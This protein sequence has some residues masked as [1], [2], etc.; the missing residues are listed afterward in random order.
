MTDNSSSVKRNQSF[1]F[2]SVATV[3]NSSSPNPSPKKELYVPTFKRLVTDPKFS[4]EHV[5]DNQYKILHS[6]KSLNIKP[7]N[8]SIYLTGIGSVT[9]IKTDVFKNIELGSLDYSIL[10]KSL[11]KKTSIIKNKSKVDPLPYITNGYH[12]KKNLISPLFTCCDQQLNPKILNKVLYQQKEKES[13]ARINKTAGNESKLYSKSYHPKKIVVPDGPKDYLNKTKELNRIRYCMNL[14]TESIKEH[15]SNIKE[16][17][18]SLDFTIKSINTYKNNLENKFL[19]EYNKQIRALDKILLDEKIEDEKLKSQLVK[20]QKENTNLLYKIKKNE[21]NTQY[22]EKWLILQI[23]IKERIHI[24]KKKIKNYINENYN[25]KLIIESP[26]EFDEIFKEK[27]KKNRQLMESLNDINREKHE[28]FLN[29]EEIKENLIDKEMAIEI[30]EKEKLLSLL[31]MRNNELMQERK[32]AIRLNNISKKVEISVKSKNLPLV[33][34]KKNNKRDKNS[35]NIIN[36]SNIFNLIQKGF[37][38]IIKNDKETVGD[39]QDSLQSINKINTKSAKALSQ[40]R[41]I[42]IS[43]IYL[44]YYKVS[45]MQKNKKLYEK[46]LEEIDLER[47]KMKSVKHK[48]EEKEGILE[49]YK[50]LEAKKEKIIFRSRRQDPYASLIYLDKIKKESKKR[51]QTVKKEIDIYDFLYDIEDEKKE[52]NKK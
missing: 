51:N 2:S 7:N 42:E 52:E 17:I 9:D 49:L 46:I 18:K 19:S 36:F 32:E 8:G 12:Y 41:M 37:D 13:M 10:S 3:E 16:Q 43:Y 4:N 27:E 39:Y 47:K 21:L 11:T 50:R 24:D 15:K 44:F 1:N 6:N 38:Y 28:L 14:K 29:L 22:I 23:Y 20:I 33:T 26:E 5:F 34:L 35:N 30:L 31:K 40:L 25:E 45:N 48:N